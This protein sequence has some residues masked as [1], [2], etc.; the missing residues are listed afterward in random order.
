MLMAIKESP[1]KQTKNGLGWVL[2]AKEEE[3]YE[4]RPHCAKIAPL[5]FIDYCPLRCM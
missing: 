3:G 2:P 1:S 5:C 4:E